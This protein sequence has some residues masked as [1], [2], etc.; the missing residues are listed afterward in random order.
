VFNAT[1]KGERQ[2][3]QLAGLICGARQA[4]LW[5]SGGKP[6]APD[7]FQARG[8]LQV[9]LQSL[10]LPVEDRRLSD[11][12]LLHPGRGA[13]VVIEGRPAGWFGQIHPDLAARYDLPAA[14][15]LF[16]LEMP[17]LLSA[18]TRR[19]RWLPSFS[20][21]ATV[22]ASERD[23][24]LVVPADT[25]SSALL[26]AIRKAGKP[27]LE[28][29]ELVDRYQG[30]QVAAGRCSQAFRLRY[31]DAR[32]TLTDAEVDQAHQKIRAALEKQ[33]GAELRA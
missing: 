26:Q 28:Q 17:Q 20:P 25:A 31:R 18:A 1:A 4:E 12:P 3:L 10:A 29:A 8:L 11:Q 22:P 19:N 6:H 16:Q 27:L 23:L 5:S 15:Y 9:A 24:A 32:R 21:F 2:Q 30:E 33:F 14:T 13:Q 7:Y